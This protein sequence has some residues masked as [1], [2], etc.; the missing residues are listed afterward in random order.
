MD[1]TA[2]W[3]TL[4]LAT[5]TTAIL[6]AVGLPLAY[7]LAMTPWRGRFLVEAVVALP[8]VLPPTVV[9]FYLLMA[10]GP[11]SPLGAAYEAAT[12][13]RLAFS[14]PGILLGSLLCNLPFTVRPFLAAFQS[15]NRRLVE[16]AWCLGESGWRTFWRVALPLSWPGI[17]G[18]LVLTFAHTV[19]E[20]GVVLMVGGNIPGVTRTLSIAIYDDVEAL[21]YASAGRTS[22]L[23]LVFA[24]GMLSIAQKLGQ[25]RMP[26]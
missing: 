19:G 21:D 13:Q 26:A 10:T 18:G 22:L 24:I 3:L 5:A 2:V 16:A 4:Q 14:F 12:G 25:R 11:H 7:W 15:M 17:L 1:F 23:L 8:L 9:G 6:A 20:F